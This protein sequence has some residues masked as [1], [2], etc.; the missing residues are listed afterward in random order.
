MWNREDAVSY[1]NSHAMNASHGRCAE[2]TRKAVEAG[3]VTLVR[4]TSARD[5]GFSLQTVGFI[6]LGQFTGPYEAGD[7]GMVSPIPHHPHGH[8]AMFNGVNWISDFTQLHGWYPGSTYQKLKPVFAIYRY[9]SA[10]P[11]NPT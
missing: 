2:Y 3:G 4:H 1:L 7:V 8:M 9:G 6:T 10:N 11:I 5:Y